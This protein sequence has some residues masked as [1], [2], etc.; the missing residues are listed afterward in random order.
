MDNREA[1]EN[2]KTYDSVFWTGVV[3]MSKYFIPLVNEAFGEHFT[4]RATV[5]LRPMKQVTRLPGAALVQG[6][7]DSLAT[8]SELDVTKDYHFE[9]EAWGDDGFAI[10]IA[11]YAAGYAYGSVVK[12]E[13]GAKMT[14]PF[15]AVIFLR[16]KG[17][18]P[19]KLVIEIEYPGGKVSYEAPVL[20]M[21][22]YSIADLFEKRLLLLLPFFGFVF[23]DEFERMDTQGAGEL[24]DALDEINARLTGMVRSGEIDES[25]KSH[26]IDWTQRVLQKLTVKYKN[27]SREVDEI[28][29]GYILH[30]RTDDILDAGEARGLAKGEA[31]GR[32]KV[33][34]E[35]LKSKMDDEQIAKFTQ[36]ATERIKE[37]KKRLM[38]SA[39]AL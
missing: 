39:A 34:I 6:E 13:H 32:E 38:N 7:T 29:G 20:D 21:R 26:L 33:A 12:T 8:L 31:A 2:E 4:D 24:K 11:E 10:R 28:M 30:T 1:I 36:L 37:L 9:M 35:M 3:K 15:S 22:G 14:I 23:A 5:T 27:V 19:D 16:S 17:N 18:L 25:Q